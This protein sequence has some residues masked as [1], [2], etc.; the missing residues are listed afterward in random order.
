MTAL[1]YGSMNI[2]TKIMW[3]LEQS[4]VHSCPLIMDLIWC[5]F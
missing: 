5:W 4:N 1:L 3:H 2:A